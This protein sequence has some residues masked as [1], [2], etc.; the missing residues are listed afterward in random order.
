MQARRFAQDRPSEPAACY[1]SPSAQY[2]RIL[3]SEKLSTAPCPP[4]RGRGCGCPSLAHARA[5][6]QLSGRRQ[7]GAGRYEK[8][9]SRRVG[10]SRVAD[11]SEKSGRTGGLSRCPLQ[12]ASTPECRESSRVS[13]TDPRSSRRRGGAPRAAAVVGR[14][15]DGS[16]GAPATVAGT[17]D[18]PR[19]PN[20]LLIQTSFCLDKLWPAAEKGAEQLWQKAPH[21]RVSIDRELG[22][23]IHSIRQTARLSSDRPADGCSSSSAS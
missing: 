20:V 3:H 18:R 5:D 22:R 11:D 23:I 4:T 12:A 13:Q 21:S 15:G 8:S 16:R 7:R 1:S 9:R 17:S 14:R 6:A 10:C 19:D 2:S